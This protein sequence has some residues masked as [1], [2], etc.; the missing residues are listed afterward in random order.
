M[1]LKDNSRDNQLRLAT[2]TEVLNKTIL[3]K[4]PNPL[5]LEAQE[6]I[7]QLMKLKYLANYGDY[8]AEN[9]KRF[10]Q[11]ALT[12][13]TPGV[14]SFCQGLS[15]K[16]V[17]ETLDKE[18]KAPKN[19]VAGPPVDQS[20][21][22]AITTACQIL[23]LDFNNVLVTIKWYAER[24]DNLHS[25]IGIYIANCDWQASGVQLWRDICNIPTCFGQEEY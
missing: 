23:E 3:P 11:V 9:C 25:M 14:N 19:W 17:Q 18:S 22:T 6:A 10:R 8:M 15:W 5:E 2:L 1:Y 4:E 21:T 24:N 13:K 7:K 12:K 20:T 16:V